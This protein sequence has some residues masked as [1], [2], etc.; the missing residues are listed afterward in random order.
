MFSSCV[1]QP[2]TNLISI[3]AAWA[4]VA[5]PCGDSMPPPMP[6]I[7]PSPSAQLMASLAQLL[8]LPASANSLSAMPPATGLP[9]K[10]YSIVTIC[11]RVTSSLAAMPSDT[12]SAIAHALAVSSQ[13]A[14]L[15]LWPS[16]L[17][18]TAQNIALVMPASGSNVVADVPSIR[19]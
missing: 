4:L 1:V 5:V 11:S 17:A 6:E 19:P 14:P 18:S 3:A 10:R 9:A 13:L 12:P 8:T 15:T 7:T 2:S 16:I